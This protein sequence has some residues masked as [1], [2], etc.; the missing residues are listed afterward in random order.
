MSQKIYAFINEH[1]RVT[2]SEI[3]ETTGMNRYQAHNALKK[4]VNANLIAVQGRGRST[5]YLWTPSVVERVDAA[6]HIR[7]MIINMK[8]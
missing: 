8:I 6:N 2:I 1:R 7:D 4:L 5:V 3:M